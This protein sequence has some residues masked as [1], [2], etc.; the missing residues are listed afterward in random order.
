MVIAQ[1]LK[2]KAKAGKEAEL[3]TLLNEMVAQV[4]ALQECLKYELYQYEEERVSFVLIEIWK[5]KSKYLKYQQ[6]E[7][8]QQFKSA[9]ADLIVQDDITPLKLTQCLTQQNYWSEEP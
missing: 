4:S 7:S 2:F 1:Q 8:A 3:R 5:S 6:S 9:M